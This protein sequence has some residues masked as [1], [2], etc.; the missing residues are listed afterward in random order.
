MKNSKFEVMLTFDVDAETLWTAPDPLQNNPSNCLK[1]SLM[2]QASYGPNVAMPRILKLLDDY[3][4]KSSFFIPGKVMENYPEMVKEI[5]KRGHEIGNHGYSHMCPLL[6]QNENDEYEEYEKS[7][8]ILH[9]LTNKRPTGFRAPSWEFSPNTFEILKKM[10]FTYDSSMM[11][12]DKLTML[13][14]FKEKSDLVE[15]PV[16]WSLDDAPFWLLSND[17]WGAPMPA[18][19]SVLESWSEEFQY[20]YEEGGE[21]CFVLTCHP[22]IIGRPG[23]L[24][25]YENLIRFIK[26]H[27]NIR[28]STCQQVVDLFCISK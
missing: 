28:F 14:I 23:R 12:A 20:L 17:I 6:F 19:S 5:D 27:S 24:R 13:E 18:P 11:G 4:I 7:S 9:K 22:Q 10:D 1:P 21:N 26:G 3:E 8:E 2:S 16:N 15:V 25:M